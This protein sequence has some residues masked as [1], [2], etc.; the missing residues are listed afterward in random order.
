MRSY[1]V[2]IEPVKISVNGNGFEL[3]KT[4]AEA[5]AE[6]MRYFIDI[7]RMNIASP[8]DVHQILRTG[9]DLVDAILGG[10]ACYKIFGQTPISIGSIISLL[11]KI[12]KD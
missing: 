10:G 3:L 6:I 1:T 4:D 2:N 11:G 12:C 9:C 8:D 7:E 5:Q